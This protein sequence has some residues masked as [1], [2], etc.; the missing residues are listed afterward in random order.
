MINE[1]EEFLSYINF[2]EYNSH[3]KTD[4]GYLGRFTL[5]MFED[6]TGFNRVLTIL[7]RGYMFDE[8]GNADITRAER[9]IRAWCSVP[10]NKNAKPLEDWQY[11]TDF[12]AL[13]DEFPELVDKNGKGWLCRHIANIVAYVKKNPDKVS[14]AATTKTNEYLKGFEKKWREKI[15]QFHTSIYDTDTINGWIIRFDGIISDAIELGPLREEEVEIPDSILHK[16]HEILPENCIEGVEVLIK[17]YIANRQA[18]TDWVVISHINLD[19]YLGYGTFTKKLLATIP[20]DILI[21]STN[22]GVNR[23]KIMPEFLP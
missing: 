20:E 5:E 17:Y 9:A 15:K 14:Q 4:Y 7:A 21:R 22:H 18:D 13:H 6:L 10:D 16:L 2:P 3:S 19:G 1:R 11:I 12:R 8:E 23:Y